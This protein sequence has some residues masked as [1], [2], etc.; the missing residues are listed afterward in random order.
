MD[1]PGG[2]V[3]QKGI[4][5]ILARQLAEYLA[6]A[7]FIVDPV[8]TML[9]YN[10]AAERLLGTRYE[11]TGEMPATEWSTVFS[12][13][14]DDGTPILPERLPLMLALVKR[15]PAY[16][17]FWITG[18]DGVRHRIELTAFP[19][20]GVSERFLGAVAMFSEMVE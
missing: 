9:Y 1:G 19:L 3:A 7:V 13:T 20:V 14:D 15:R 6:T 11:E 5:L 8:G 16:R 18:L 12:P 10:E 2:D 4:E 17:A